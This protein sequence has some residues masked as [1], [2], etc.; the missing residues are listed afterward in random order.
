M[1]D[2]PE[3]IWAWVDELAGVVGST[4]RPETP[5]G[6]PPGPNATTPCAE[7]MRADLAP[8]W[9]DDMDAAP[10]D[11]TRIML[12][13]G[14]T[15]LGSWS[16]L[17]IAQWHEDAWRWPDSRENPSKYKPWTDEDLMDG[18]ADDKNF[19]HWMPLPPPPKKG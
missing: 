6:M 9:S 15:E 19:T 12:W 2:A 4:E 13:R 16:E 18:Y 17:I 3:R 14:Y 10:K 8:G 7:Y 11:G 5:E 1:T